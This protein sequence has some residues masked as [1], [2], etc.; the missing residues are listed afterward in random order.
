M[1]R[2]SK[3]MIFNETETLNI[4]HPTNFK[5]NNKKIRIDFK[6]ISLCTQRARGRI[7]VSISLS[8]SAV[9][10]EK[11]SA[12]KIMKFKDRNYTVIPWLTS[13]RANEFFG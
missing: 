7:H 13:D 1:G 11:V 10:V 5:I 3:N 8:L 9:Q 6:F 4:A 12:Q 2:L